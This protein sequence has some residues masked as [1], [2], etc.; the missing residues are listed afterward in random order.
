[1]VSSNL[2][3]ATDDGQV[4][5]INFLV[6]KT[7]FKSTV[8]AVS[9]NLSELHAAVSAGKWSAYLSTDSEAGTTQGGV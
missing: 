9:E 3:Q 1:M 6:K 7:G 5:K 4:C 8:E 2:L